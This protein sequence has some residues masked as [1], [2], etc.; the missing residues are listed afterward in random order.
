MRTIIYIG[1][2][3]G[4]SIL[5]VV[6]IFIPNNDFMTSIQYLGLGIAFLDLAT[7]ILYAVKE[8]K[9][10]RKTLMMILLLMFAYISLSIVGSLNLFKWLCG[11]KAMDVVTLLT[12]LVS[13]PQNLYITILTRG[14]N[15]K[16]ERKN[17]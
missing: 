12:L 5:I 14:G 7:N 6:R 2:F 15:K 9:I 8:S 13:L 4:L 10:F 16:N 17:R 11:S 3:W 1:T